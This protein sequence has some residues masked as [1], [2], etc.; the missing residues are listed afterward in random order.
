MIAL[1]DTFSRVK[2]DTFHWRVFQDEVKEDP[3]QPSSTEARKRNVSQVLAANPFIGDSPPPS[4]G[5]SKTAMSPA[6]GAH[7]FP[8]SRTASGSA[9]RTPSHGS[10]QTY[11]SGALGHSTSIS[12]LNLDPR[13]QREYEAQRQAELYGPPSPVRPSRSQ[14]SGPQGSTT[15][16]APEQVFTTESQSVAAA[17]M[18]Q[19]EHDR[20]FRELM[21]RQERERQQMQ[22]RFAAI[23]QPTT[24]PNPPSLGAGL[25]SL[26]PGFAFA[27]ASSQPPAATASPGLRPS[28]SHSHLSGSHSQLSQMSI[29]GR[30]SRT[31]GSLRV[32]PGRRALESSAYPEEVSMGGSSSAS[33]AHGMYDTPASGTLRGPSFMAGTAASLSRSE[34]TR[35]STRQTR[36]PIP[37]DVQ[38]QESEPS[39]S[40]SARRASQSSGSRGSSSSRGRGGRGRGSQ[41]ETGRGKDAHLSDLDDSLTLGS[42]VAVATQAMRRL[43]RRDASADPFDEQDGYESPSERARE[44]VSRYRSGYR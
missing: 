7:H 38:Q 12:E 37:F 32:P 3:F 11:A 13:M 36:P 18:R 4:P 9:P 31:H 1:R 21:A 19:Q 16:R 6:T 35:R 20:E 33:A 23:G 28:S 25:Q 30:P 34:S 2:L 43:S 10:R 5:P 14:M 24:T 8:G 40:S 42:P 15:P 41:P 27:G 17:R 26:T 44:Q 22:A 39:Q 29:S